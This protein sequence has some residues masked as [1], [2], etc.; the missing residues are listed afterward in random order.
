MPVIDVLEVLGPTFYVPVAIKACP[1]IH[2]LGNVLGNVGLYPWFLRRYPTNQP[3]FG[4][5]RALTID[6]TDERSH[7]LIVTTA[8]ADMTRK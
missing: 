7:R 4:S 1:A 2:M 8:L 6:H 3:T 5:Y